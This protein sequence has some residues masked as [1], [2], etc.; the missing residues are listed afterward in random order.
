MILMPSWPV[1]IRDHCRDLP[2]LQDLP[3]PRLLWLPPDG[4]GRDWCVEGGTSFTVLGAGVRPGSVSDPA[5][6]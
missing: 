5:P 6:G 1:R 3:D 2:A 4:L